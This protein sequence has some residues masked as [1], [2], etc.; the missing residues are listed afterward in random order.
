MYI[1]TIVR[2]R[3]C[4]CTTIT[5]GNFKKVKGWERKNRPWP[6]PGG[7]RSR[8]QVRGVSGPLLRY[9]FCLPTLK[10]EAIQGW[11]RPHN[12]EKF[13]GP[14]LNCRVGTNPGCFSWTGIIGITCNSDGS[15]E[16]EIRVYGLRNRVWH[17]KRVYL[18]LREYITYILF[19]Y[20]RDIHTLIIPWYYH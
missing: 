4:Y 7:L 17:G 18:L 10:G 1:F 11:R 15:Y 12:F 19:T 2:T 3:T 8:S 5:C 14:V 13:E 16:G 6:R 9:L 20:S